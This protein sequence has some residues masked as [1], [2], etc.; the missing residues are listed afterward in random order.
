MVGITSSTGLGSG[1]DINGIVNQLVSAEITP[2]ASRL[3][4]REATLQAK[5]SAVGTLKGGMSNF[6]SSLTA[7]KGQLNFDGRSAT[8]SDTS[9]ADV[10]A[11]ES[12][13]SGNY[14]LSVTQLADAHAL[15]TDSALTAAQ[16]TSESSILGTGTLTFKFGTTSYDSVTDTYTSFTQNADKGTQSVTITDGSLAGIRDAINNAG[17]GVTAS[18]INDGSYYRLAITS[19][20]GAA[21]SLEITAT[22]DDGNNTDT[23]GLSLLAFNNSATNLSQTN[24]GQDAQLT[25][26]GISI[27]SASNTLSSAVS[28]LD[29]TLNGVG[30]S[31][32]AVNQDTSSAR[33]AIDSFVEAYNGLIGTI[34]KLSA[35]DPDTKT[36]GP[37]QG[38]VTLLSIRSQLNTMISSAVDGLPSDA[39][40]RILADVGITRSSTGGTMI[41]DSTKLDDALKNNPKDVA[42]LFG[43]QGNSTD[44][45][46]SYI[47]A[48]AQTP[49]GRYAVDITSLATQGT[50]VGSAAANLTITSGSNDTL[51]LTID[52]VSD[53]ITVTAGTYTAATLAAEIQ[54]QINGVSTFSNAGIA[55][56]VAE[57]A[58]VLTLTSDS[59]GSSSAISVTGGLGQTDLFGASPVATAG[60]DVVGSIGSVAG[61]GSGQELT[62]DGGAF[63]L[64][65]NVTGTAIGSRGTMT[66]TRGIG[67]RLDALMES[68][69]A[70]SNGTLIDK[71]D[72]LDSQIAD[73]NTQREA[74]VQRQTSLRARLQKQFIALDTLVGQLTATSTSL[75]SQLASIPKIGG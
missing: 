68:M 44:S 74:L 3:D 16:F 59:Y 17:M 69:L 67:F 6:Q 25:I 58:G 4:R 38:D 13:A 37:L 20:D 33:N 26:N 42:N 2:Q 23:S 47:E 60:A 64:K 18:I 46:V 30:S 34:N 49:V 39:P 12:A 19:S 54:A 56:T 11:T 57:A 14:N 41:V 36:A 51:D 62:G 5:I 75:A 32:I 70:S 55:V 29:I 61:T 72:S 35:Y 7:L 28:G 31:S 53:S 65:V 21:S 10:T 43:E 71:T 40:Y 45:Q 48:L 50:Y 1:L 52:G 24:A 27:A 63:G 66:F 22:D 73:L 15:V 9:V 8:S